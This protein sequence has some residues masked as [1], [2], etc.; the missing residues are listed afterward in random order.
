MST[1]LPL[2]LSIIL[3]L[4]LANGVFAATEIAL[5]SAR[6]NRLE[7]SAAAGQ[8]GAR[9]A[10]AL[11]ADPDRFLATVQIGIT[12]IGT[13]AAAFGGASLASGIASGLAVVPALQPYAEAI[14]LAIVVVLITYLSLV[15]GELA[16]KR[17]ALQH[18][19]GIAVRLAPLMSLLARI[20]SPIIFLLTGSVSLLL[21]LIGQ[22]RAS[23]MSVTEEDITYLVRQGAASG[24]V[25]AHEAEFIE[26]VFRFSTRT[27][28]AVMTPRPAIVAV[29]LAAPLSET[30]EALIHTGHSR[31]PVYRDTL[32]EVIGILH[33]RD[34]LPF[35]CGDRATDLDL[36]ALLR[37]ALFLPPQQHIDDALAAFR[38]RK[39]SLALVVDEYGQVEGLVTVEDVLEELLGQLPSEY[40]AE[41]Q[42]TIVQLDDGSWLVDGAEDY[43][44][45][46]ERIG[47]PSTPSTRRRP[48]ATIA[49]YVLAQLQHI[50]TVGETTR[51]GDFTIQVVDMDGRRIDKVA[52]RQTAAPTQ[53]EDRA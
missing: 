47:T 20:S 45:V 52:I 41:D 5:V 49:G 18:A 17:L 25:E 39:V 51:T 44:T 23:E 32:D 27:V 14:A 10:L 53:Q 42:P 30:I 24:A 3:L 31:V 12:L 43:E 34:L 26:R 35:L 19:E 4:I 11:A 9:Q 29:D 2:E 7:Q 8:R 1:T 48:Y 28:R 15:L 6:R 21:R 33:A 40:R 46:C 38:E 36:Q 37:P 22:R 13:L 50:P 16:P